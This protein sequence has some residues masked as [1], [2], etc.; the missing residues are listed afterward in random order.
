SST[1]TMSRS[2]ERPTMIWRSVAIGNSP[3]WYLPL[4]KRRTYERP[5]RLGAIGVGALGDGSCIDGG[6]DGDGGEC[7]DECSGPAHAVMR[8]ARREG[9]RKFGQKKGN[10]C[11]A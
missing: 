8:A 4:M 1:S 10:G 5:S 7:G 9:A 3:P 6:F 11:E 2:L